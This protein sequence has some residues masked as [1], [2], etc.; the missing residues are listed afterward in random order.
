MAGDGSVKLID[1]KGIRLDGRKVDELRP[2]SIKIGIIK[3]A[4]GSA[5]R[6][7]P[8]RRPRSRSRRP[9]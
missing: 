6:P 8:F 3:N 9:P 1:E 4:D 7:P 5:E 2:V